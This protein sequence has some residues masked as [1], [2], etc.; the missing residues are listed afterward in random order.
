MSAEARPLL[1][2][3]SVN[4]AVFVTCLINPCL[5]KPSINGLFSVLLTTHP[6]ISR[7]WSGL[8]DNQP[9]KS[10]SGGPSSG[11]GTA[12]TRCHSRMCCGRCIDTLQDEQRKDEGR[13]RHFSSLIYE[14][15]SALQ[16]MRLTWQFTR[17]NLFSTLQLIPLVKQ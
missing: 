13:L 17:Q 3:V 11:Y 4:L 16:T 12:R 10:D 7:R 1:A 2:W 15:S 6:G 8:R 5:K 14:L 9:C